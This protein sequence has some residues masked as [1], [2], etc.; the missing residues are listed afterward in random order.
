MT[1]KTGNVVI[2]RDSALKHHGILGQKWGHRNGPPYPLDASDHSASER[3]A[4][5]KKSLEKQQDDKKFHLTD[6]QKTMIKIGAAVVASGLAIYGG[7]KLS[8]YIARNNIEVYGLN[9]I[10]T[11]KQKYADVK[12]GLRGDLSS[13]T[14]CTSCSAGFEIAC[15]DGYEDLFIPKEGDYT[16]PYHNMYDAVNDLFV[17][18]DSTI[19]EILHGGKFFNTSE[20]AEE[21]IKKLCSNKDGTL[22]E[23]A[24][25]YLEGMI[26]ESGHAFNWY[27]KN[28]ELKWFDGQNPTYT[29][30]N[31]KKY[32]FKKFL[33]DGYVSYARTDNLELKVENIKH[34]IGK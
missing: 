16:S 26:G 18:N 21:K 24:R 2:I 6:K 11:G 5:W 15:R 4:G 12:Y 30:E 34:L 13:R 19:K 33:E 29:N 17:A 10:V 23:G 32:Y 9:E 31:I 25:G 27:V 14:R 22:I 28:G 7:Y 1:Y 20:K 8:K 3:K